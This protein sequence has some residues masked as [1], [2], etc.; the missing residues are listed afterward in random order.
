MSVSTQRQGKSGLGLEVQREAVAAELAKAGRYACRSPLP[1]AQKPAPNSLGSGI[2]PSCSWRSWI[3]SRLTS[4]SSPRRWQPHSQR[5]LDTQ[6]ERGSLLSCAG[7]I[8]QGDPVRNQ[9]WPNQRLRATWRRYWVGLKSATEHRMSSRRSPRVGS[10]VEVSR[11]KALAD[12]NFVL[13]QRGGIH[14]FCLIGSQTRLN[15]WFQ[16]DEV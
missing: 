15:G 3:A 14:N 8:K 7:K 13:R 9:E 1:P 2:V 11:P 12:Q 6:R 10:P 5:R 4:H 16:S